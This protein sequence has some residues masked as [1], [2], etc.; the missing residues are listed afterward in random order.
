MP[1]T[2]RRPEKY[3]KS[4]IIILIGSKSVH[5]VRRP[6]FG[7]FYQPLMMNLEQSVECELAGETEV[8]E[9]NLS[10]YYFVHDKSHMI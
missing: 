4:I 5:L 3:H 8:L 7:L 10:Q 2:A 1:G 6:Q 9:E